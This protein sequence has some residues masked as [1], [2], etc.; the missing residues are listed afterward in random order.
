M[1]TNVPVDLVRLQ[2]LFSAGR[3]GV[4]V[5]VIVVVFDDD[6]DDGGGGGDVD[7]DE[8]HLAASALATR[9]GRVFRH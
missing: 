8:L 2:V 3:L 1:Q 9:P 5:V 7:D 4:V 6:D